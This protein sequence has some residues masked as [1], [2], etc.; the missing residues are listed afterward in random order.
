MAY[1]LLILV[2]PGIKSLHYTVYTVFNNV[3]KKI[4]KPNQLYIIVQTPPYV[5]Q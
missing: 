4:Q 2:I 1:Y 3:I 5:Q